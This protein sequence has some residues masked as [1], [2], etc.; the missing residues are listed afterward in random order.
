V[1]VKSTRAPKAVPQRTDYVPAYQF[2]VRR[3]GKGGQRRYTDDAFDLLALVALDV[4][5][6]AY[7]PLSLQRQMGPLARRLARTCPDRSMWCFGSMRMFLDRRDD[8]AGWKLAQDVVWEKHNTSLAN[9]RLARVHE[10]ALH[11]YRG[12]WA[13][14][15]HVTPRLPHIGPDKSGRRSATPK[16]VHGDQR[17]S[18]YVDDGKRLLRSVIKTPNLHAKSINETEK[19]AGLVE[20]LLT[21][22]CPPDGLVLDVFAGGC[23][24]LVAARNSGR[25]AV[26]IELREEQCAKAVEWRLSQAVLPFEGAS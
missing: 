5:R 15:H 2:A 17:A 13:D 21:Y 25:R 1:Q 11:W 26:G 16:N 20:N 9:D 4:R 7:M 3:S 18:V 6:I 24:T 14:V 12:P 23:S 19:P 8:F 10:H 22:G